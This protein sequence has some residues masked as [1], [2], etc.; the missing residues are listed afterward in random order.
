MRVDYDDF[1]EALRAIDKREDVVITVW[2][3]MCIYGFIRGF[4]SSSYRSYGQNVLRVG[5][6]DVAWVII[7]YVYADHRGTNVNKQFDTES[8]TVGSMFLA[9]T[10]RGNA[11]PMDAVS[12]FSIGC[13]LVHP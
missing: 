13:R 10:A 5:T 9:S 2:Q 11:L 7:A 8:R 6:Q 12:T 3:G 1:V 4:Q